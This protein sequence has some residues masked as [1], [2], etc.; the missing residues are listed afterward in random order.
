MF[1]KFTDKAR[2]VVVLA[3][4]E[5]KLLNHNYIGTEH[6][7]L[8]LI[9]EGEGVAAKALEALGLNLETVR[10]QVQET[11][12][13]VKRLGESS[14]EIGDITEL[15][16]G[17]TEQTQVLALNAAIPAASAGEAGREHVEKTDL[18]C[19]QTITITLKVK[20][21][22]TDGD[23]MANEIASKIKGVIP[24]VPLPTKRVFMDP[25]NVCHTTSQQK[26]D[27]AQLALRVVPG[28]GN[29]DTA[30]AGK[31]AVKADSQ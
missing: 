7:L 9:H 26:D 31:P 27:P 19:V 28:V 4:E 29:D 21:Y 5:A 1:E 14:L 17:I 11:A 8:G 15:I 24:S 23:E 3:Q 22:K 6:I 30:K 18:A 10:E 16:A 12:K 2:R 13:R 25:E 20:T